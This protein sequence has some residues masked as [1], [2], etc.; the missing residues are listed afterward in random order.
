MHP[1][2]SRRR[3][4]AFNLTLEGFF[5]ELKSG[6]AVF[7]LF[8]STTIFFE[9]Y[10][11]LTLSFFF[12][13]LDLPV[14][15]NARAQSSSSKSCESVVSSDPRF[16]GGLHSREAVISAVV[17]VPLYHRKAT[18]CW[19]TGRALFVSLKRSSSALPVVGAR[20]I[21]E[22][23]ELTF[24]V[25]VDKTGMCGVQRLCCCLRHVFARSRVKHCG[26]I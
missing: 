3:T 2:F 1:L 11:E 26:G 17:Y 16:Y 13:F 10:L 20:G 15:S 19:H 14:L 25:L 6:M 23:Q 7:L 18:I 22:R 4:L 8:P 5:S 21:R 24:C 9:N 12:F